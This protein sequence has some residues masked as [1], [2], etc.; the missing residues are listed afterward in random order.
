MEEIRVLNTKAFLEESK[1]ENQARLLVPL[2]PKKVDNAVFFFALI[3]V[4]LSETLSYSTLGIAF[5]FFQAFLVLFQILRRNIA[6]AVGMHTL[7]VLVALEWLADLALKPT[8][9]TYRT[10][11][12]FGVSI[13]TIM[14][15]I[16]FA[17]GLLHFGKHVAFDKATALMILMFLIATLTGVFG[18]IFSDYNIDFFVSD[19]QY[20]FVLLMSTSLAITVFARYPAFRKLFERILIWVLA[21]RAIVVFWVASWI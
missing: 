3:L 10:V 15:T 2:T 1:I 12:L 11:G 16:F 20:W 14:L 9:C 19:L 6:L 13:S 21:S 5:S 17:I 4:I 8:I 18:V 7:F